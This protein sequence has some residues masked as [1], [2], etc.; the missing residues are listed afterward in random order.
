MVH[1]VSETIR[2]SKETKAALL[3]FASRLQQST[4]TR[5]DFDAAIAHLVQMEDTSPDSFAR[6]VGSVSA[7][8]GAELQDELVR[9]RRLD[10]LRAKRKYGA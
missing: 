8:K 1:I 2:V 7:S 4:G 5:I 10:E 6:F 9:E 3:R